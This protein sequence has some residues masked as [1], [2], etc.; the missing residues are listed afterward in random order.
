MDLSA[1]LVHEEG[2]AQIIGQLRCLTGPEIESY[3]TKK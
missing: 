3:E 1:R 2:P